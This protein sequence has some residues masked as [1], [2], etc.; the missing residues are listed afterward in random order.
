MAIYI[1]SIEQRQS[2]DRTKQNKQSVLERQTN[3]IH[4][5]IVPANRITLANGVCMDLSPEESRTEFFWCFGR[6]SADRKRIEFSFSEIC[7]LAIV[8]VEYS[9]RRSGPAKTMTGL[10]VVDL[11]LDVRK[12]PQL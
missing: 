1:I 9:F 7:I 3:Y 8:C 5:Y 11:S 4:C 6:M 2:G 12:S 10:S